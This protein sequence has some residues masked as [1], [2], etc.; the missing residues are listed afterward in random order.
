MGLSALSAVIPA[1]GAPGKLQ[2]QSSRDPVGL[3]ERD[4]DF[5]AKPEF[6]TAA[7]ADEGVSP[8]IVHVIIIAD[9]GN[10]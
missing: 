5:I 3:N 2:P 4:L 7:F 9:A 6:L 8:F 10:K 1:C